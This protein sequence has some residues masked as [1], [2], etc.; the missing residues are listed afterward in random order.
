MG[1]AL[2]YVVLV[3]QARK[4][5][6]ASV[7]DCICIVVCLVLTTGRVA[8]RQLCLVVV[9]SQRWWIVYRV[10]EYSM[11]ALFLKSCIFGG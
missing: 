8:S 10:V 1:G 11:L 6:I 5:T 4:D 2:I 7:V 3:Y 9:D